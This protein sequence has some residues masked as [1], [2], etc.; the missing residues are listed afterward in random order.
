M[1]ISY[2][3][4]DDKV[5]VYNETHQIIEREN[6]NLIKEILI[7]ENTIEKL[8][9]YLNIIVSTIDSNNKWIK[10]M[11]KT[12]LKFIISSGIV[13][14][15]GMAAMFAIT[16]QII[17]TLLIFCICSTA[18]TPVINL[19]KK[20]ITEA[21]V[22]SI[23]LEKYERHINSKKDESNER[24]NTLKTNKTENSIK[25]SENIQL[26]QMDR[27]L[28]IRSDLERIKSTNNIEKKIIRKY[29]RKTSQ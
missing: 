29:V 6:N 16:G 2:E 8:N 10:R 12:L 23:S 7:E 19:M 11:K 14:F 20:K 24:L 1:N 5:F 18:F 13:T 21:V 3:I 9:E 27:L 4:K 22:D 17:P 25:N 26:S 28:D 15:L